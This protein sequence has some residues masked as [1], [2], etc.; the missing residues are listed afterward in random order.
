MYPGPEILM[1]VGRIAIAGAR[2][3][4]EMGELRHHL[5]RAVAYEDR[6]PE[7]SSEA[8]S[9]VRS[10]GWPMSDCSASYASRCS[11]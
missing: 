7:A 6:T 10:T 5:D 1:E 3:D 9:A 4:V 2:L 11:P 8:S